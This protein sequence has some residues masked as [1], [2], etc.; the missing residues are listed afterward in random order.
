MLRVPLVD[1][2]DSQAAPLKRQ[3]PCVQLR[4][5]TFLFDTGQL[6]LLS[7]RSRL[8]LDGLLKLDIS[9]DLCLM[10]VRL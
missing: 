1:F 3:D 4:I 6:F 10:R 2:T 7:P 8:T 9:T 5:H